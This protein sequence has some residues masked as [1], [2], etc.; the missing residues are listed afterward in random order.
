MVIEPKNWLITG[1]CGFIGTS[2][3]K[4]LRSKGLANAIRVVDNLSV[5]SRSDLSR[6]TP[7]FETDITKA[8]PMSADHRAELITADIRDQEAA[9]SLTRG[10]EVVVH[11]AAN[12]GVQPSIQDPLSDMEANVM[13]TVHY[14]EACRQQRVE[15]FIFASSGAPIGEGVPPFHEEMACHPVS[16]YG[17]SK[18]A[19]EAY[20]SAYNRSFGVKTKV[21]RFS[22]VYGPLSGNKNSVVARFINQAIQCRCLIINGNGSQTRDFLY[23]D[24]L[25]AVVLRAA[26]SPCGGQL[27]QIAT[28]KETAISDIA[29]LL[30]GLLEEKMGKK[31]DINYGSSL[32][33]DVTRNFS[34][35][36]RAKQELGWCPHVSLEKGLRHTVDWFFQ[37]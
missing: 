31:P 14:L 28:Q 11:L 22:N 37:P 20:C 8:G 33:G 10:A 23:I 15:T 25:I 1:G 3:I 12:T 17:A 6:V 4:K 32:A 5:G 16:P 2:L 7:F 30:S 29:R 18:L 34:D 27:F 35:I 21:L 19:G 26:A 36:S 13:G 9:L 24:D